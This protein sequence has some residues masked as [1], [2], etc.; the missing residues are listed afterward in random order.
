MTRLIR[1][2]AAFH[3]WIVCPLTRHWLQR[4][5]RSYALLCTSGLSGVPLL[6]C[7]TVRLQQMSS[8][9][10]AD[11]SASGIGG[12]VGDT[13]VSS[14]VS[15]MRMVNRLCSIRQSQRLFSAHGAV[16]NQYSRVVLDQV[17]LHFGDGKPS[18]RK[19]ASRVGEVSSTSDPC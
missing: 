6:I 8:S 19:S 1:A 5:L 12:P 15:W 11:P 3:G 14:Q 18:S 16:L 10:P 4:R 13:R 2:G 9:S 7:L 17:I